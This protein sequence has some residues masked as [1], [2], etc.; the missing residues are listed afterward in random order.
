MRVLV[1]EPHAEVRALLGHVV[2]RLGHEAVF[3]SGRRGEVLPDGDVDV[4]L[5]EPADPAARL[6]AER[7]CRRRRGLPVICASIYPDLEPPGG[8]RPFAYL[9]KPFGL[10]ELERVLRAAVES[11][12]A[13]AKLAS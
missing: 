4:L 7:V 6:T 8:L 2:E 3:P 1:V 13:P 10:C 9:V 5:L 11:V 12:A